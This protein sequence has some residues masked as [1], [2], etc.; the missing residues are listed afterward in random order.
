VFCDEC[1]KNIAFSRKR[2]SEEQM[3]TVIGAV[4]SYWCQTSVKEY[5]VK[6]ID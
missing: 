2:L 3:A 5:A 4:V 6:V 1:H